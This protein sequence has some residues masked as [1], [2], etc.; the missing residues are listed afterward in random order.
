MTA[1]RALR[2]REIILQLV[3]GIGELSEALDAE[4]TSFMRDS[5]KKL[6]E[7]TEEK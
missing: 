4:E 6:N 3:G 5:G 1:G 2:S 7:T